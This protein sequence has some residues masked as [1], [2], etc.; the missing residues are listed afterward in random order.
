MNIG[1]AK[2][3]SENLPISECT[4]CGEKDCIAMMSEQHVRRYI[5]T[6]FY[7]YYLKCDACSYVGPLSPDSI[8][9]AIEKWNNESLE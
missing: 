3:D 8:L 2:D 4:N 1:V 9:D 6:T 5:G 7:I